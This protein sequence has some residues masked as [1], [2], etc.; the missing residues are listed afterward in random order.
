MKVYLFRVLSSNEGTF[1]KLI[2]SDLKF[3]CFTGECPWRDNQPNISCIPTGHYHVEPYHSNHFGNVY[4]VMNVPGRTYILFH[5]GNWCGDITKGYISD[6][7][8][9]ILLGLHYGIL[10]NQSAVLASRT[11]L[12]SF[13]D[14]MNYKPFELIIA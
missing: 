8:G 1:G 9:C 7:K 2:T 4:Q 14:Y 13:L 5:A 3:E 10:R 12:N 6:S 11:A